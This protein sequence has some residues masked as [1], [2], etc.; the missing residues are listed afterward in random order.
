MN[1][2][3]EK[4]L[5]LETLIYRFAAEQFAMNQITSVEAMLVMKSISADFN[6]A[7]FKESLYKRIHFGEPPATETKT[8]I[9]EELKREFGNINNSNQEIDK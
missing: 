7:C 8:G 4:L 3:N 9:M 6:D 1:E 2:H 5:A